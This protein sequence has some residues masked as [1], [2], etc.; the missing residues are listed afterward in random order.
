MRNFEEHVEPYSA[1]EMTERADYLGELEEE[2]QII[3]KAEEDDK[4]KGGKT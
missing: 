1:E 2:R 3:S 4:K